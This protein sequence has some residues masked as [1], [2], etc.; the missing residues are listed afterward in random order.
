MRNIKKILAD[1]KVLFLSAGIFLLLF[2]VG[3]VFFIIHEIY[4]NEN[5]FLIYSESE[6]RMLTEQNAYYLG[7][8]AEEG[9]QEK[10]LIEYFSKTIPVSG[11][12]WAFLC[13]GDK[14][15]YAKDQ[16]MTN[17]LKADMTKDAFLAAYSGK[18]SILTLSEFSFG[19]ALYTIGM[20]SDVD[21]LMLSCKLNRH[22]MYLLLAMGIVLLLFIGSF[23]F[24]VLCL[25][26]REKK[27]TVM[28]NNLEKQNRK[29]EELAVKTELPVLSNL[30]GIG[31][32]TE[33]IN[34][35][36]QKLYDMDVILALLRKSEKQQLYPFTIY[37]IHFNLFDKYFT[38]NQMLQMIEPVKLEITRSHI[39]AEAVKGTF[40]VLMYQTGESEAALLM[41]RVQKKW[42]ESLPELGVSVTLEKKTLVYG[43]SDPVYEFETMYKKV[44]KES[45][46]IPSVQ[47]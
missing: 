18:G 6:Q 20:V 15:L 23:L 11:N 39:L 38:K 37:V 19:D 43:N 41:E 46:E 27:I 3:E 13:A 1:K 5:S 42:D 24:F 26:Q 9:K 25:Y 10:E 44:R 34:G 7:K 31:Q 2:S 45:Y 14:I 28:S 32:E 21:Y 12:R 35:E 33:K 17:S 8:L 16:N 40:A 36:R 4:Q 29:L 22:K 47:I 30:E